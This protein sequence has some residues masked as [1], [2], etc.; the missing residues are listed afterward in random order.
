M[1]V[2]LLSRH[3]VRY[4]SDLKNEAAKRQGGESMTALRNVAANSGLV[5]E[6]RRPAPWW[7]ITFR[8]KGD[9]PPEGFEPVDTGGDFADSVLYKRP[10]VTVESFPIPEDPDGF[11]GEKRG[12]GWWFI[13]PFSGGPKNLNFW[14]QK[15]P[16]FNHG[17]PLKEG[18][19]FRI[20]VG[21]QEGI[22]PGAQRVRFRE[23]RIEVYFPEGTT[24]KMVENQGRGFEPP[25]DLEK[26]AVLEGW[27]TAP[28]LKGLS[29]T[30]FFRSEPHPSGWVPV[31][32]KL[33]QDENETTVAVASSLTNDAV[34]DDGGGDGPMVDS[35]NPAGDTGGSNDLVVAAIQGM[36]EEAKKGRK[37]TR[38]GFKKL[39]EGQEALSS[40]IAQ[41]GD[42]TAKAVHDSAEA[43]KTRQEILAAAVANL[44]TKAVHERRSVPGWV[45]AVI[46]VSGLL[47][48]GILG[49][50]WLGGN[51]SSVPTQEVVAAQSAILGNQEEIMGNQEDLANGINQI[52][53]NQDRL[54]AQIGITRDELVK[55]VNLL[56]EQGIT[57]E[58]I[59][60]WLQAEATFSNTGNCNVFIGVQVD[61]EALKD[62]R[63]SAPWGFVQCTGGG[64]NN[65]GSV[66]TT[67]TA[68][69]TTPTTQPPA[70]TTTTVPVTTTT[71]ANNAPV[72]IP[73]GPGEVELTDPEAGV[74]FCLGSSASYDPDGGALVSFEWTSTQGGLG[75]A[76]SSAPCFTVHD[77]GYYSWTLRV[78]D[79]EGAWSPSAPITVKVYVYGN[80]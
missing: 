65:V 39:G 76:S 55:V 69:A 29:W 25:Q 74:N 7:A 30:I 68:A 32:E 44:G 33:K 78:K 31:Q 10:E 18:E 13:K 26:R 38:K 3:L 1:S 63:A 11:I 62:V 23:Q 46:V 48:F 72:A 41:Q 51:E 2:N 40:V 43:T 58:A 9:E 19:R 6:F 73:S 54:M 77:G 67:T 24:W 22:P 15:S 61:G 20:R 71:T 80:N 45:I 36:I 14:F 42:R 75:N 59:T 35:T 66:S 57:F 64:D 4:E 53:A 60:E 21:Y 56:T 34:D 8:K 17:E 70:T 5:R 79:N 52:L 28:E 16:P 12:E 50:K 47:T 37:E 27:E 49:Y